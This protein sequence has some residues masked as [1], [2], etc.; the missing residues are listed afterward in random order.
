MRGRPGEA[1]LLGRGAGVGRVRARREL[2]LDGPRWGAGGGP[3]EWRGDLGR[4][5]SVGL[6]FFSFSPFLFPISNTTQTKTI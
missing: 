6:G 5:V 2:A 3:D 4:Q 1:A